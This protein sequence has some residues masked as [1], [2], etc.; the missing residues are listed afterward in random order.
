VRS[1][2]RI[3]SG[4]GFWG[5]LLT[6]PLDLV[7]KG[8]LDY[9][10]MD[11]LAEVTMSILQKQKRKD[12]SLGYARD[13]VP[14]LVE[15]LPAIKSGRLKVITNGGGANPLGCRDAL[16][17]AALSALCSVMIFSGGSPSWSLTV[18]R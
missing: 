12:P 3:G 16:F 10:V 8:P 18:H 6:A 9:L 15:L 1:S 11:Y 2:I 4:Q 14:L 17:A 7:S 13:L 5:D